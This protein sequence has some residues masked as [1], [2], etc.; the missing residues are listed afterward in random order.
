MNSTNIFLAII[1]ILSVAS[2]IIVALLNN[3]FQS[4]M[5]RTEIICSQKLDAYNNW[6]L[7]S[8]ILLDCCIDNF[9]NMYF[10]YL[11]ETQSATILSNKDVL[12]AI[13]SFNNLCQSALESASDIN[14]FRQDLTSLFHN[15]TTAMNRDVLDGTVFKSNHNDSEY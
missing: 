2:P 15:V 6:A 7:H 12:I 8:A 3:S 5:K 9:S 10:S 1:S 13:N 4:K 11:K 14:K